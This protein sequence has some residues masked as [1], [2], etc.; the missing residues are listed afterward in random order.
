MSDG[1]ERAIEAPPEEILANPALLKL[2]LMVSGLRLEPELRDALRGGRPVSAAFGNATDIDLVLPRDTWVSAPVT[3]VFTRRSP[4]LLAASGEGHVVRFQPEGEP[5]G[6]SV[7]VQVQPP[8][9]FYGATTSSGVPLARVGSIHGSFLALSPT[10]EC[11]FLR[12]ADQCRFCSLPYLG[13][14]VPARIPVDDLIE[15]VRI[16]RDHQRVDMVYL[17]TGYAAGDDSG[18]RA[19]E[20]AIRAIKKTFDVLVGI[21]VLP[22]KTNAWVD[23]TYAMGVDSVS[24]NLEVFDPELFR[25][26]CPGPARALGRDRYLEALG[27]ATTVFPSGAVLCHLIVGVEPVASTLAGIEELT[28]RKVVP[29][30]PMFRPFKGLDLRRHEQPRPSTRELGELYAALYRAVRRERINLAWVRPVSVVSTPL[31]GRFFV[32]GE[33]WLQAFVNKLMGGRKRG[34]SVVLS[35]WRRALRVK[36]VDDSYTSSGL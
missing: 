26:I 15:A 35:D 18:V 29:V 32:E 30:L 20:S 2:E 13:A 23:R 7:R 22:P 19:L 12:T 8:S 11:R 33:T 27:Y 1:H 36:E 4:W 14:D 16:A 24:Y 5:E 25:R 10:T 21:D 34:P 3:S 28:R 17:S 31:E 6:P 9:P